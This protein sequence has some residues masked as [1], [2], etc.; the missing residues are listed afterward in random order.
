MLKFYY[1]LIFLY[2]QRGGIAS[3]RSR[4]SG[5]G[6]PPAGHEQGGGGPPEDGQENVLRL[7]IRST[8]KITNTL[9]IIHVLRFYCVV[10]YQGTSFLIFCHM[11]TPIKYYTGSKFQL[12]F[13]VL[14]KLFYQ[15]TPF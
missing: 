6:R 5:S 11:F 2:F 8:H 1:A 12:G 7:I 4:C 10:F 3:E 13:P 14:I 15:S 9:Y